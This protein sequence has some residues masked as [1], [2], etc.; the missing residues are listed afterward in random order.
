[1]IAGTATEISPQFDPLRDTVGTP[2]S[3]LFLIA[4][5]KVIILA[6]IWRAFQRELACVAD[7]KVKTVRYAAMQ[8]HWPVAGAARTLAITAIVRQYM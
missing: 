4:A 7:T 2:V 3:T 8:A 5:M 6:E 1:M